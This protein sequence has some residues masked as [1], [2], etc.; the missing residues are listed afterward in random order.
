MEEV[1]FG[2]EDA[3]QTCYDY[4]NP[5]RYDMTGTAT[6]GAKRK[7]KMYDGVAQDAFLTWRD[8]IIGWFVGP[9]VTS[10]GPGWHKAA[11]GHIKGLDFD[12]MR[13]LRDDDSVKLWLQ[14]Y[15]DQM[16]YEFD[17][18]TF[19]EIEG[20]WL[21]DMGSG[22]MAVALPEESA[23]LSHTVIRVPHPARWWIDQN[24]DFAYDVYHEKITLT[25]RQC[26]QK[27]NKPGDTLAQTVKDWARDAEQANNEITL[28]QCVR[29]AGDAIFPRR[30]K[31][32]KFVL[33][34][35]IDSMVS[36]SGT[37]PDTAFRAS[38]DRLVRIEALNS[39][40]PV[41][42]PLRRNSDELYGY[43]PAMDV[44]TVIEAA[45][46]H[47][48]NLL[49]LGNLAANPMMAVPE[50]GRTS[51]SRLP[52]SN[53]YYGS[54][55]R[56]PSV[57]PTAPEYPVA[58]DRENKLH[59]LIYARYGYDLWRMMSMYQQKRER[60]Q[61]YE[62]SEARVDQA[63]LMVSQTGGI[64]KLGIVPI[65]N[66]LARIAAEAGRMPEAPAV[67]QD[68]VGQDVVLVDPIGPL[69]QLQELAATVSPLQQGLRFLADIGEVVGRHISPRM[70]AQL[71]HRVNLPDLAE[72]ALDKTG[73]PRR[74][75]RSDDEVAAL[76]QQD[77]Q[78]E[79]AA[80]QAI[81]AQKMAAATAQL[82]KPIEGNSLLAGMVGAA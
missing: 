78:N 24:R 3:M 32:S 31:W 66:A 11:L 73:F 64:W 74:L 26:L 53:Y 80:Q 30:L 12:R 39:F 43:S 18:S 46:Q 8:G 68:A 63:R 35:Y 70:A 15:T 23:D 58:I 56:I 37:S 54:E 47:A 27:Y 48:Y 34:T 76:M 4:V 17:T 14:N 29:P 21:Q 45:Q 41:I 59:A 40:T 5:R 77:Q 33:V 82:G 49:N 61:A 55:K 52:K 2:F 75:M 13:S 1:R 57:I 79:E 6:K 81:N 38:S 44:L 72:F 50:E 51:F 62:V 69:A 65:Y 20:E 28:V 19:Y 36:G 25:A 16:R 42:T 9:A 22:G 10:T 71:Y 67:L 7:T 60:N